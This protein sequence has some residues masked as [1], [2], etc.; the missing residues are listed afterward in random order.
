MDSNYQLIVEMIAVACLY[1]LCLFM[2][3]ICRRV[4]DDRKREERPRLSTVFII[5]VTFMTV[6]FEVIWLCMYLGIKV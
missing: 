2:A 3:I 4:E 6:L 5:S 1:G